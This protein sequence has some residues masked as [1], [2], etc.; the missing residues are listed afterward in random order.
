MSL[1]DIIEADAK[2]VFMNKDDFAREFTNTRT[3]LTINVLFD[4]AF[5]VVIGDVETTRPA[6]TVA[7]VDVPGVLHED[8]FTNL[9]TSIVYKVKN[10]QPDG[11]G[12]TLLI[13]SQD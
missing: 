8:T 13:L 11:E 5:I 3:G 10:I 4:N 2:N 9:T 7:S 1:N 6:I 12:H